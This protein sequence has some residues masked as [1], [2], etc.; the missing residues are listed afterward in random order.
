MLPVG[1]LS[2]GH[3]TLHVAETWRGHLAEL[4]AGT[5]AGY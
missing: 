3:Q 2:R 4:L 5:E 1:P